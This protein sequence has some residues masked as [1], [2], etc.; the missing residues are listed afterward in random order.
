[1]GRWKSG[2]AFEVRVRGKDYA[3]EFGRTRVGIFVAISDELNITVEGDT[4]AECRECA[5]EA[6]ELL[7][8]DLEDYS[9]I[10]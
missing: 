6:V 4:L 8:E 7:L 3:F 2:D 1:M 10:S 5:A 9:Y